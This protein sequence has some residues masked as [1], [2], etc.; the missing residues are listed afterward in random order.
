MMYNLLFK[1]KGHKFKYNIYVNMTSDQQ[2]V[3]IT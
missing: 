1:L 2:G 3:T